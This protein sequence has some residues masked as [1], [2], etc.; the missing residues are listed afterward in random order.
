[1]SDLYL[2]KVELEKTNSRGD[3]LHL[4]IDYRSNAIRIDFDGSTSAIDKDGNL[5]IGLN[6][7]HVT[8]VTAGKNALPL[9]M[10]LCFTLHKSGNKYELFDMEEYKKSK[11]SKAAKKSVDAQPLELLI[12][13]AIEA[14]NVDFSANLCGFIS[15]AGSPNDESFISGDFPIEKYKFGIFDASQT[16]PLKDKKLDPTAPAGFGGY[17]AKPAQTELAKL[18]DRQSV[19]KTLANAWLNDKNKTE[20]KLDDRV[21]FELMRDALAD[22]RFREYVSLVC[23]VALPFLDT[24]KSDF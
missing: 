15:I 11:D 9:P 4:D 14:Q 5:L 22:N 1:M 6:A 16:E 19:I 12:L 17:S 2:S 20:V 23:G 21:T 24:T 18:F 10:P 13:K 7:T 3:F 8:G